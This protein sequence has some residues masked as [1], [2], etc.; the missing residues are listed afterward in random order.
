MKTIVLAT[1]LGLAVGA[2]C[3]HHFGPADAPLAMYIFPG[4]VG[5]FMIG[6][7]IAVTTARRLPKTDVLL[8]SGQL[9]SA[10][11]GKNGFGDYIVSIVWKDEHGTIKTESIS[12]GKNLV[13]IAGRTPHVLAW[14]ATITAGEPFIK[15]IKSVLKKNTG[16]ALD[17]D[18]DCRFEVFMPETSLHK[19]YVFPLG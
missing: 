13:K 6:I 4:A 1:I 8:E 17:F 7:V 5:G 16:W 11:P 12:P 18:E 2:Y 3:M 10:I 15:K 9:V 19:G 14:E